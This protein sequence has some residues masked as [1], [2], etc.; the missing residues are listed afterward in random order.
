MKVELREGGRM[1]STDTA[2]VAAAN[3]A[4]TDEQNELHW[5]LESRNMLFYLNKVQ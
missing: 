3:K 5:M 4:K 2:C 1:A